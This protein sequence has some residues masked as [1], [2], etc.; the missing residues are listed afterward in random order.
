MKNLL[1]LL[2]FFITSNISNAQK[3]NDACTLITTAQINQLIGCEVK[4]GKGMMGN[5]YCVHKSG[6]SKVQVAIQYTNFSNNQAAASMLKLAHD[7]NATNISQGK[8]A[9]GVYTVI[10]SFDGAGTGAYYM[11]SPGDVYTQGNLVRLQFV[12][13]NAL[14]SFDTT[15]IEMN[16]V[17]P[18]LAEIYKIIKGNFKI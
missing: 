15:A 17:V 14:V 16:K 3:N 13:G 12:L 18:K 4:D 11:T 10:K 6:D 5:K 8:K 1:L 2:F 7:E 9:V